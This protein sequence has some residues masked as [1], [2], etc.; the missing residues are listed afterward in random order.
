MSSIQK[1]IKKICTQTAVYWGNPVNDGEGNKVCDTPF[2]IKCRWD[3]VVEVVTDKH[4]KSIE[5]RAKVLITQ[6][7][8]EEGYLY[9]GTIESI[10][11]QLSNPEKVFTKP[12][13]FEKTYEIK[14]IAN[15][16]EIYST[17]DF[18]RIVYL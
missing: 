6:E 3:D 9:L 10:L 5:S 13:T 11:V 8:D 14:R 15:T 4:G 2:E 12:M 1:F 17:T 16:P 7:L 18:V